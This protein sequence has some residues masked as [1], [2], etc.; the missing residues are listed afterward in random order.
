VHRDYRQQPP[1][2]EAHVGDPFSIRSLHLAVRPV[3]LGGLE[4]RRSEVGDLEVGDVEA[5]LDVIV[6]GSPRAPRA[7]ARTRRWPASCCPL[8]ERPAE[9]AQDLRSSGRI[10]HEFQ[11]LVEPVRGAAR[12]GGYAAARGSAGG[13]AGLARPLFEDHAA[14]A[15]SPEDQLFSLLHGLYRLTSNLA[16]RRPLAIVSDDAHWTDRF[17]LR[18]LLYAA[19]GAC[20]AGP[21]RTCTSAACRRWPA[22]PRPAG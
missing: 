22:I 2:V 14:A 3:G 20:G 4:Q 12:E 17:T 18:V 11:R 21:S 19:A 9:L 15:A 10:V 7:L 1:F 16:E 5:G 13:A 8:L 6:V